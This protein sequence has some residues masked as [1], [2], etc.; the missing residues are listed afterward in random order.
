MLLN[1]LFGVKTGAMGDLITRTAGFRNPTSGASLLAL[2][3]PLVLGVLGKK[4]RE[5]G[6]SLGGL[7]TL[8]VAE[9]ENILS[10]A[11][12][13]LST[14]VEGGVRM[15][16]IEGEE[17]RGAAAAGRKTVEEARKSSGNRWLW[18]VIGIAALA[19]IWFGVMRGRTP[20][21][22]SAVRTGAGILD[23]TAKQAGEAVQTAAGE[24]SKAVAGLGAFVKKAL[25]GGVTLNVPERGIESKLIAF[26]DD[27]SRPVND[28]TWFDFD[29]LNFASG[30][31]TILSESQEQVK[32]IVAVLKAYPNVN[33]KV[34]GY[35]DNVGSAQANL[36]LSERRA[37]A[38]M[39]ALIDGGVPA[40]RL[41]AEGYGEEHPV[42]DNST[43]EGRARNRRIALKVTKK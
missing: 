18:P 20:S 39:Q 30:S 14:I 9:R 12:P 7:T 27:K 40:N 2:A 31:A 5:N 35:T 11:P 34:G 8:L 23:T 1:T 41:Q 13:E 37:K 6:M 36:Q 3:S 4:V 26:I 21:A 32:N 43:E 25:P 10:A 28:T 16:R 17:L 33:V 19:L 42:A 22:P 15:P 24:V 38:V 29:R